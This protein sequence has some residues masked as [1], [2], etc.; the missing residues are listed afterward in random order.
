MSKVKNLDTIEKM[1]D[2]YNNK[3]KQIMKDVELE[4]LNGSKSLNL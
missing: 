1:M 4:V 2:G 3:K